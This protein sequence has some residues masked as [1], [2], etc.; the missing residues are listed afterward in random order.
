M[1]HAGFDASD[2]SIIDTA[3]LESNGGYGLYRWDPRL[4]LFLLLLAVGLNIGVAHLWLSCALMLIG[5]GLLIASRVPARS[6]LLFYLSPLWATLVVYIGFSIGFGQTPIQIIGPVTFYRE[7]MAMGTSA[8]ARVAS[9]MTWLAAVFLTT[10]FDRVLAAFKWFRL[11][12]VLVDTMAMAYRYAFLM[13]SEFNKMRDAAR[14][15]GGMRDYKRSIQSTALILSQMILRAYDRSQAVMEAMISRGAFADSDETPDPPSQED[16]CP[17]QCDITPDIVP[18]NQPV[19]CIKNL[20]YFHGRS[21]SIKDISLSVEKGEVVVMCGPNGAGKTTL[22]RLAS[23]ILAANGGS[24]HLGDFKLAQR[25]KKQA[26]RHVGF[27]AQDPNDQLFCTHVGEDIAYGPTQLGLS[28]ETI[29]RRVATAMTLMEVTHLSS[30]PIHTLSFGEMKRVGLAGVIAM[31][32]PLIL[33]DEPTAGLDPAS[34]KHLVSLIRHLNDH[35]GYTLVM[36]T[37]DI[38]MAAQIAKRIVIMDDG[39]LTAD[40]PA[41]DILRDE[42]LLKRSRLEPPILTQ[43]FREM[44]RGGLFSTPRIPVTIEE[45]VAGIADMNAENQNMKVGD[46]RPC[47]CRFPFCQNTA[48]TP[49]R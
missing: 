35:H 20:S 12:D 37:H 18:A 36:V 34:A 32:P 7:G 16:T 13:Y 11:P 43:L 21:H 4:K 40:G 1:G 14:A 27:L 30:R 3:L 48:A 25:S 29:K 8:A 9:D 22:L 31:Q 26:F 24:I 28:A 6:F 17:N 42:A 10:P 44:G 45:A 15:R 38:N 23:G 46:K 41:G 39:R 19:I 33:M 5:F 47:V 2:E 49:K